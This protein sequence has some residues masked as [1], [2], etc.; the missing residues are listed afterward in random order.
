MNSQYRFAKKKATKALVSVF[1]G[2]SKK[3]PHSDIMKSLDDISKHIIMPSKSKDKVVLLVSDMMEHSSITT[4]Y[5]K[6]SLKKIDTAKEMKKLK[7]SGYIANFGTAEVY[8]IGAGIIGGNGYRKSS[9]LKALTSFWESYFSS[10]NAHL[11]AFGTPM[12]LEDIK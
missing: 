5:R 8:V 12:L 3:L 11:K 10:T 2:A 4:F 1:K 9:T 6:G 7:Q